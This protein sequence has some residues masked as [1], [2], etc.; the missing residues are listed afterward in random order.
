MGFD[1]ATLWSLP[2]GLLIPV[3]I[4]IYMI[5]TR[6][7][8]PSAYNTVGYGFVSFFAAIISVFVIL[9]ILNG[10][11]FNSMTFENQDDGM[12]LVGIIGAVI[13]VIMYFICETMKYIT[14]CNVLEKENNKEN[15]GLGFAAGVIIAQTAVIF[16]ISNV[17]YFDMY[18]SLFSGAMVLGTG[19]IYVLLSLIGYKLVSG[20][21][22][23]PYFFLSSIYYIYYML[24]M[25]FYRWTIGLYIISALALAVTIILSVVLLGKKL[26]KR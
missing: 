9:A 15:A 5:I 2:L 18:L 20:N 25:I 22:K 19:V 4:I 13:I 17:A 7:K 14:F 23:G 8:K 26:E 12:I 6:K 11:F 24:V 3:A 10:L 16:I 1:K 21:Y